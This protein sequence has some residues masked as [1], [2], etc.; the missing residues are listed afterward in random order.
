MPSEVALLKDSFIGLFLNSIKAKKEF[1]IILVSLKIFILQY[2][3]EIIERW[4]EHCHGSR[5]IL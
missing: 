5:S 4:V 1:S 3:K 2:S